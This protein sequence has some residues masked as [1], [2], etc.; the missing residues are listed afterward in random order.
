MFYFSMISIIMTN[1]GIKWCNNGIPEIFEFCLKNVFDQKF[2]NFDFCLKLLSTWM[3][4]QNWNPIQIWARKCE[5]IKSNKELHI[6]MQIALTNRKVKNGIHKI[7]HVLLTN[8][9]HEMWFSFLCFL[10]ERE[11]FWQKFNFWFF[12]AKNTFFDQKHRFLEFHQN[13]ILFLQ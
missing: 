1:A 9:Q 3:Q 12:L 7:C 2:R 11:R 10:I 13:I 5:K 6:P 4:M 8:G